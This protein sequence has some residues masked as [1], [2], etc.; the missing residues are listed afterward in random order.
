MGIDHVSTIHAEPTGHVGFVGVDA[1]LVQQVQRSLSRQFRLTIPAAAEQL[2]EHMESGGALIDAVVLGFPAEDAVRLAQ[3]IHTYD[4]MLP[5]LILSDPSSAER[6]KRTLMFSPFLGNEVGVWSTDDLDILPAALHDAVSRRRQRVLH[7]NTLA[8]AQIRLEKFPLQRPEATH[9]LDRLLDHAPVGVMTLDLTG[10]VI[11]LNRQAQNI[12]A[13]SGR[14]VLG[15]PLASCFPQS[16][17]PRLAMLQQP[18]PPG[19][20]PRSSDILEL[21][22]QQGRR[23]YVEVTA[24]PLAYRTGQRGLM[25]ILQDV[26]TRVEAENERRHA[27]EELRLHAIVLRRFHEIASSEDLSLEEKIDAVLQ[28]GCHQFGLPTG[29]V[30]RIDERSLHVIRSVGD[31]RRYQTGSRHEIENTFCGITVNNPEPLALARTDCAEWHAH[32]AYRASGHEA[33]IGT[34]VNLDDAERG[35]LCFFGPNP[36]GRPFNSADS[37]LIKLMSRWVGSE[38]QRQRADAL[39][40]KL[41]GALERTAD[42]IIIT[43]HNRYIEYVNPS[44][45]TLTGYG[46]QEVIGKK[47]YF[48]RSGLHDEKF[49]D[50]LWQVIGTG[51]VF[52]GRLVNRKKDGTLYHEQKTI[53]PLKDSTG[54]ITHFISAGHDI[55]DLVAAEEKNRAHQA[56]LAHVARLST[57]GEMTSGLAHELNQP[58]CAITTY[59]QTCLH[60]IQNA[61]C[62][63]ERV[64]YG[65]EQVV[66]QAEL[67]SA[68]FRRLRDFSRKGEIHREPV[69]MP[70]IIKEVVDFVASEAQQKRV[71]LERNVPDDIPAVAADAI[72]IEQVLLNLVRNAMEAVAQLPEDRRTITL[73][74][75]AM[76]SDQLTVEIRDRG[77][78][79]SADLVEHLFEPFITSKPDGLG[80]GLSISQGI[81][82][83][84]GGAL[85]L[86]ENS[87]DGAVFRF[88]LPQENEPDEQNRH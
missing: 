52:R 48:L 76:D 32:P 20:T 17:R 84:H 42:A 39:M 19:G 31:N 16:E 55:T 26:T 2:F 35:T 45:E 83:A 11:T 40:R 15:Q 43:D 10:N 74:V 87:T 58:L 61:D 60:I 50:E 4:K 37:E 13:I 65:L 56:E 86:A 75:W 59:A 71:R 67:A 47:S 28:L 8:I 6:L 68:I 1:D 34:A 81:V 82:E 73:G 85:W 69:D 62:D 36:R 78:G 18:T 30:T 9:Y 46:R 72:Q 66:K 22:A 38:L 57:L 44:F 88:T 80:I 25:L 23:Q 14:S 64:R 27:E 12:L 70:R 41:S 7:R 33:Y 54:K 51:D 29:I 49:Y 63:P 5:V 79:C 3:R 21:N 53:S 77:H 24:A